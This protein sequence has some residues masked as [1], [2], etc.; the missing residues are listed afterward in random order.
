MNAD[1][2]QVNMMNQGQSS[3]PPVN[4]ANDPQATFQSM[5]FQPQQQPPKQP[6]IMQAPAM[7]SIQPIQDPLGIPINYQQQLH[8]QQLQQQQALLAKQQE[9]LKQ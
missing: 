3:N 4:Q 9:Q 1:H 5:E 7:P 2:F 8:Q 6:P